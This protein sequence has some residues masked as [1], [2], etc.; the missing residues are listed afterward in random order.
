MIP[1]TML[2][3]EYAAKG[4]LDDIAALSSTVVSPRLQSVMTMFKPNHKPTPRQKSL[5]FSAGSVYIFGVSFMLF[6]EEGNE[7]DPVKAEAYYERQ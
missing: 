7:A 5:F 2:I 3:V 4:S 1:T 6:H